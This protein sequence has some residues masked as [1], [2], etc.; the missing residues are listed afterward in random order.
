MQVI[1]RYRVYRRVYVRLAL[2]NKKKERTALSDGHSQS[3]AD[4]FPNGYR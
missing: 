3:S 2:K 4:R 1:D